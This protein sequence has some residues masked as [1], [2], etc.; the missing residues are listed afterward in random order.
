LIV[1][2]TEET[3]GTAQL[4]A[5]SRGKA[6]PFLRF[7]VTGKQREHTLSEPKPLPPNN[8]MTDTPFLKIKQNETVRL[9]IINKTSWSHG[10][11][12]HG[13]HFRQI[14]DDGKQGPLRDTI[15]VNMF[16]ETIKLDIS[17]A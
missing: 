11:H 15:L 3:N 8:G 1:D 7:P 16:L 2:V 5:H 14:H 6:V 12:L 9:R 10:M 4:I 17:L 13:H